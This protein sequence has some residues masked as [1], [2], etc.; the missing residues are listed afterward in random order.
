M[1]GFCMGTKFWSGVGVVASIVAGV[2]TAS[3][4]DMA[5]KAPVYKAPVILSDWAG[6]YIGINGGYG[7]GDAAIEG[8]TF[9]EKGG[10]FGG[11]AGYNWQY[12]N[13][14]AGVEVDFDGADLKTTIGRTPVKIDELASARAR[15]GFTLMPNVL[16]YGTAGPGWGHEDIAGVA[17]VNQ[18]GWTA[19]VG[20]EYMLSHNFIVRGEFLHYDFARDVEGIKTEVNTVRGG[21]SYKF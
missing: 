9:K 21:L 15:L 11:Q 4:A 8:S 2:G 7:W 1:E 3:A 6:F 14:V 16:V 17:G 13:I 10:L 5:V 20:L 19:G 18:F 12:G